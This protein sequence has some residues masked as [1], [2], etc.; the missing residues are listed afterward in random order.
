M[1]VNG[2]LLRKAQTTSGFIA[3]VLILFLKEKS[4]NFR[5]RSKMKAKEKEKALLPNNSTFFNFFYKNRGICITRE[6]NKFLDLKKIAEF[7]LSR[8][9]VFE[10]IFH[11]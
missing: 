2:A 4:L 8:L 5:A 10:F 11:L 6:L 1:D 9:L 7:I 3:I